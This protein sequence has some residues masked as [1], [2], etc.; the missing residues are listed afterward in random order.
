MLGEMRRNAAMIIGQE[1]RMSLSQLR[2]GNVDDEILRTLPEIGGHEERKEENP[3]QRSRPSENRII[4]LGIVAQEAG[5]VGTHVASMESVMRK[6]LSHTVSILT[7]L[8]KRE[9]KSVILALA[10][11]GHEMLAEDASVVDGGKESDLVVAHHLEEAHATGSAHITEVFILLAASIVR[12][13]G[14]SHIL[15]VHKIHLP[16]DLLRIPAVIAVAERNILSSRCFDAAVARASGTTIHL[17][18]YDAYARIFVSIFSQNIGSIV[19]RSIVGDDEFDVAI[20]LRQNTLDA[21]GNKPA[22]VPG[23]HDD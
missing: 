6:W 18:Q 22:G 20:S 16:L 2:A 3:T 11:R 12:A 23:R 4:G 14:E 17:I 8:E 15:L 21:F 10:L 7:L 9:Q 19:G 5:L 13:E 1:G